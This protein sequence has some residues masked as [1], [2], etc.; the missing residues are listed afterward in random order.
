[1]V[2]KENIS[3]L[4]IGYDPYSEVW[5]YFFHFF[6]KFVPSNYQSVFVTVEEFKEKQQ[7]ERFVFAQS[8]SNFYSDRLKAGLAKINTKYVVLLLDDYIITSFNCS[9]LDSINC[10]LESAFPDFLE[11]DNFISK[12]KVYYNKNKM[13]GFLKFNNRYRINLQP[14]IWKTSFLRTIT[15]NEL[16]RPW[17]FEIYCHNLSLFDPNYRNYDARYCR[18]KLFSTINA[19]D[20]GK[21]TLPFARLLK[22]ECL[23]PDRKMPIETRWEHFKSR[24]KSFFGAHTKNFLRKFIKQKNKDKYFTKD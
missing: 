20:K 22:K 15:F 5:P 4:T 6:N 7:F 16:I 17:D 18:K 23:S 1:M 19:I 3:F 12:P 21:Y 14:A 2:E 8:K 9:V 10:Y 24:T 13:I 11:L